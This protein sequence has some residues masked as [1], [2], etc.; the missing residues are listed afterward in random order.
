[1]DHKPALLLVDADVRVANLCKQVVIKLDCDLVI[2]SDRSAAES[3]I[4]R[5]ETGVALI[6]ADTIP[7]Y[8]DLT[9]HL[10]DQSARI[11]VVI[12]QSAATIS[13]AV[14]AI[15]AG[16]PDYVAKPLSAGMLE[17][18]ISRAQQN[19]GAFQP[20]VLPLEEVIKRAITHAVAQAE[21]DKVKAAG[22]LS[23][24]KTTLY[25]KLREYG[26]ATE[27]KPRQSSK[28]SKVQVF[29]NE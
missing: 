5:Y 12:A 8:L 14:E 16:A 6:D 4:N 10:K 29:T 11:Q 3:A 1:M 7:Q 2:A 13:A 9:K 21:G 28:Q 20:S 26:E 23:I 19:Y 18:A 25:R 15:K 24:G 27:R 22:L 17:Q